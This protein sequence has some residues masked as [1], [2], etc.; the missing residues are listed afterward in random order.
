MARPSAPATPAPVTP[1]PVATCRVGRPRSQ[2]REEEILSAALE[3]LVAEGYDA[4][5]IEGIAA[6]VG[7]GK[8]TIYRRWR[9]KAEL[10]VDAIRGYPGFEVPLV[11]TGDVRADLRTFLLGLTDAFNG[12]DGALMS[13]FTAERIRH[14]ELAAA[15]DRQFVET[16]RAHLRKIIQGAVARGELPP[17]TDVELVAGV[18]P[19]MLLHELVY[20]RKFAPDLVDR[21][22]TQ[23]LP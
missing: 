12:I 1:A 4:M 10:V 16:R 2:S 13:A 14:P 22:V 23:F 19:A 18:G 11:D 8:A 5:T 21:I 9:N 15:F 7:A 20:G 6:R 17:T 3:A